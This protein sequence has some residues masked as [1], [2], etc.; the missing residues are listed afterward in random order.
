MDTSEH[1]APAKLSGSDNKL[2][3]W[4]RDADL[5]YKFWHLFATYASLVVAIFGIVFVVR[6]LDNNTKSVRNSVQQNMLSLVTG[7][8]RIFVDNPE[9]HPYF[10]E[11]QEIKEDPNDRRYQQVFAAAVQTLDV[12]DIAESQITRFSEDWDTPQAWDN[13]VND[14]FTHSPV[15]RLVLRK[16]ITWYGKGL[17]E[18]IVKVEQKLKEME[19]QNKRPCD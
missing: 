15:L 10:Y 18:R 7:L 3:P 19:Q 16:H 13:W 6:S 11:C 1:N 5:R 14:A 17:K 9:L 2:V 4:A 8:D 12:L